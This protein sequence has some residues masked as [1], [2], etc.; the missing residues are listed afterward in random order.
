MHASISTDVSFLRVTLR[1]VSLRK[2][3]PNHSADLNR[4][5]CGRNAEGVEWSTSET[6][7][8]R[9]LFNRSVSFNETLPKK[10]IGP[11]KLE[12]YL[13]VFCCCLGFFFL[14][15]L[16]RILQSRWNQKG[17]LRSLEKGLFLQKS[18]SMLTPLPD[19]LLLLQETGLHRQ[20]PARKVNVCTTCSIFSCLPTL[21]LRYRFFALRDPA[22]PVRS[23][24][25]QEWFF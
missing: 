8:L 22:V 14:V 9:K 15:A 10:D 24:Q 18:L 23:V 7:V 19:L 3:N 6:S 12:G 2:Y 21:C 16:Q 4:S 25:E 13:L 20:V 5:F 11:L 1:C 17:V